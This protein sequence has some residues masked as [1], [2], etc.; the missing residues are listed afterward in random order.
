MSSPNGRV[1]SPGSSTGSDDVR[2]PEPGGFDSHTHMDI[3]ELPVDGVLAAARAAGIGRV[4]NVGCD[5]PSSRWS[6]SCADEYADVDAAVAIHPNATS[7]VDARGGEVLDELSSLAQ[8]PRV[9]AIGETGL[10]YYRDWS[11]PA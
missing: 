2:L 3:M 5:L 6:V 9:V 10:D 8:S 11:D 4:V 1:T 7:V